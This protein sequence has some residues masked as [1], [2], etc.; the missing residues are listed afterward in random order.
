[1]WLVGAL[2]EP[3]FF[4]L[5]NCVPW[6]LYKPLPGFEASLSDFSIIVFVLLFMKLSI[7]SSTIETSTGSITLPSPLQMSRSGSNFVVVEKK[8]VDFA[9]E[10]GWI[11][12]F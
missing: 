4:F 8:L 12:L 5:G 1:M 10:D 7:R 11:R 6:V 3:P 9:V 2:F